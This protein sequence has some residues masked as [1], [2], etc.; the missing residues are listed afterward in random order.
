MKRITA[1]LLALILLLP[2]CAFALTGQTYA[3]FSDN[4]KTDIT[5]IN[6]NT[7]RHLLPMVLSQRSSQ[8]NDGLVYYDLVG[9]VL[10]VL[11]V[12]DNTDV[13]EE[14]EIRLT[15]PVNMTYGDAVH[16]EFEISG[17]HSYALLMAMDSHSEHADRYAL[18]TD[19]ETNIKAG[20][21]PYTRQLGAYTLTCTRVDN[22]MVLNFR[23]NGVPIDTATPEPSATPAPNGNPDDAAAP[24]D[25]PINPEDYI[26]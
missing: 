21:M 17:Y 5:F 10:N 18:V 24:S 4:Y 25:E 13:I 8:Q 2:A 6:D 9:E 1:V 16:K 11:V 14:C 22:T 23:N 26:G 3:T 12:V 7:N 15:Q 20:T 19:V